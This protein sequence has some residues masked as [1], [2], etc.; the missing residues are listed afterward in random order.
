MFALHSLHTNISYMDFPDE[1][2]K[3]IYNPE[4]AILGRD[5]MYVPDQADHGKFKYNKTI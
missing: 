2:A 3:N 5:I 1:L 4:V